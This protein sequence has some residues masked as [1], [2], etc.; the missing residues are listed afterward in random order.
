[1][2]FTVINLLFTSKI[3]SIIKMHLNHKVINSQNNLSTQSVSTNKLKENLS[4]F[5]S[6]ISQMK[7]VGKLF[8][9]L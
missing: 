3:T 8:S 6:Q 9:L 7:I 1:M 2:R 4:S 5:T